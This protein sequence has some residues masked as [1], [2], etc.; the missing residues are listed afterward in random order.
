MRWKP[1]TAGEDLFL[2]LHQGLSSSID[3]TGRG[4]AGLEF[5]TSEEYFIE[6]VRL[7]ATLEVFLRC[8]LTAQE[9][10]CVQPES[11]PLRL[12]RE[13]MRAVD[14]P[15]SL[16]ADKRFCAVAKQ[17]GRVAHEK[18]RNDG[19]ERA[20]TRASPKLCYMCGIHLVDTS[21]AHN[22]FTVEH[23]WPL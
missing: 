3:V 21:A 13:L 16:W 7:F 12:G 20:A 6:M 14:L 18:L 22:Q 10:V 9:F 1:S 11:E 15:R 5:L 19:V 2:R 23:L 8:L 17:A 4:A